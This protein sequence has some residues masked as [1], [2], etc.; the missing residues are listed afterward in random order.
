[1]KFFAVLVSLV[2]MTTSDAWTQPSEL[3]RMPGGVQ[4]RWI[5]FENPTGEP[6]AG[7]RGNRG[8]KG[9]AYRPVAAGET[10]VLADVQG[11]GTI[12]RM[13]FT[14]RDRS[15]KALR[16]YV[17]RMYW[18]GAAAPAV[19]VPFGDFFGAVHGVAVPFETELVSNPEGRSFNSFVPMPFRER[20]RITFTNESDDDLLQLYYDIDLTVGDGHGDDALYFHSVWRRHRWT[21]LGEDF[22]IL[23]RVEGRGR[24]LGAHI[25]ILG[26]PDNR[27]WFGEGEVK[28]FLDG[29][30]EY[31]TLVGTGTE[32]YIGTAYGQGEYSNRWQGSLIMDNDNQVYAFYRHHV[33]DPVWFHES[34]RVTIQQM[35]GHSKARVLE[36]L[37]K[38]VAV[39]PVSVQ[40]DGFF[41]GLLDEERTLDDPD[42]PD[43][44]TNMYR[45]DDVSAVAL[46]YL[47]RPVNELPRMVGVEMRVEGIEA[48]AAD[49]SEPA[50]P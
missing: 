34:L 49:D 46:F 1:M 29:D 27:G 13:W 41:H 28:M 48:L 36:L 47:D 5:S 3:F 45:R 21:E 33:P 24:F 20:A 2:A 42:V 44:W 9:A 25:G 40:G 14:L 32:D 18:D 7:G 30:R 19:E 17:L 43:G 6:G 39:E 50:E 26:H 12:R 15:P 38:G 11:S 22:T 35:G 8:A 23:P 10:V 37:A 16:S 4:T 31:P